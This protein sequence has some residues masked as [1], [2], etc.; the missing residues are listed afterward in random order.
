MG[1]EMCIRDSGAFGHRVD[2]S[3]SLSDILKHSLDTPGVHL[4]DCPVDYSENDE[5]LNVNIK[6]QSAEI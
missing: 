6:K 4:I 1:S 3:D 5:I 2:S